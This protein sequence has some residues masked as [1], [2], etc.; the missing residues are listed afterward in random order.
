MTI[1]DALLAGGFGGACLC[2]VG[3]PF[4]VVKVRQQQATGGSSSAMSVV[5]NV[6][7]AEGV[8]GLWRGVTPP[9][10]AA[11][12]QWAVVFGANECARN[13]V[14]RYS[15]HPAGTSLR[16]T[17]IAG[18]LVAL[19]TTLIYTPVDRVKLA[20]QSDGRRVALGK[21]ARYGSVLDCVWQ[22][23]RAGGLAT[24]SRGFWATLARDVPAWATYFVVFAAAKRALL[25]S[26][27]ADVLD[28]NA[29][30]TPAASLA[31]GGLA[32]AATWAIC[33]PMDVVKTRFQSDCTQRT[34]LGVCRAIVRAS[35]ASGFFAGFWTI[36]L[37]G[38][39]RDAACLAGTEAA[40]RWLTLL[41]RR[42]H[43]SEKC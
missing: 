17:A 10:I 23:W 6:V 7:R 4:D 35:G 34:Y 27:S 9:L 30:L 18:G 5:R 42:G 36:V 37:G 29:E 43:E 20:L 21:P 14:S 3:A 11:V 1:Q 31:A 12:P 26:A 33:L 8:F 2:V 16:D 25:S 39:P 28:G 15:S 19:P 22:L 40:Q 32:G 41:R 13:I 24:F 38:V